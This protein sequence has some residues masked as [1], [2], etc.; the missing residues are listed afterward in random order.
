MGKYKLWSDKEKLY[1]QEHWGAKSVTLIA[2]HLGRPYG[3][4]RMKASEMGLL[5]PTLHYDGIT[6]HQL[7]KTLGVSSCSTKMWI[8]RY[9]FPV[10]KKVFSK[11]KRINV[12]S[13]DDFWNWAEQHKHLIN[14]AKLEPLILGKEPDWVAE[15]RRIDKRRFGERRAWTPKDKERLISL[16]TS[17]QY[18]YP[19]IARILNRPEASVKRKLF[20]MGVKARPLSLNKNIK[21]TDEELIFILRKLHEGYSFNA[22]TDNINIG[23]PKHTH[24]SANGIRGKLERMGYLFNGDTP[25]AVPVDNPYYRYIFEDDAELKEG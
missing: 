8:N 10:K 7:I 15:K 13:Y 24:K 4:V 9:N 2:K 14:F 20:D 17:Y 18:T 16:V 3:G 5:E 21:Y 23:K 19:E 25:I 6:V 22:I 12:V 1:L 11:T